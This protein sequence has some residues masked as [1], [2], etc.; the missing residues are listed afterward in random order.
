MAD[1]T[2]FDMDKR[3]KV[4]LNSYRGNGGGD[5]LTIGG[6]IQKEDLSERIVFATDKDLRYY[7]MQY[8]EQQRACIRMPCISGNSSLKNGLFR[9]QKEITSCSS[10]KIKSDFAGI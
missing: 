5:L 4:A 8:I 9:R 7:L 1:G 3:Y 6:G 2:P 10:E